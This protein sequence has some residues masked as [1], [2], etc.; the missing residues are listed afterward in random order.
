MF[1]IVQTIIFSTKEA[2]NVG[3]KSE[4]KYP[5]PVK[6]FSQLYS[7]KS[8]AIDG[9]RSIINIQ[10]INGARPSRFERDVVRA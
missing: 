6:T 9:K 8:L 1:I 5:P 7:R 10:T 4:K 3:V 2:P